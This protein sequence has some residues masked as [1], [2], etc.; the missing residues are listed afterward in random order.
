MLYA[1]LDPGYRDFG[2]YI[3]ELNMVDGECQWSNKK[4]KSKCMIKT[5]TY[6]LAA[7]K[8]SIHRWYVRNKHL[9]SK[10][11]IIKYAHVSST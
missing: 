1:G 8:K 4:W 7:M 6:T 5:K 10:N 11:V 2:I 9:L 3:S